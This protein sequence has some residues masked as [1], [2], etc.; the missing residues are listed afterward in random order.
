[1][2]LQEAVA[3]KDKEA[4]AQEYANDVI[5]SWAA[6]IDENNANHI[7]NTGAFEYYSYLFDDLIPAE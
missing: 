3:R 4:S 2:A 1:M 7:G 6:G 5:A